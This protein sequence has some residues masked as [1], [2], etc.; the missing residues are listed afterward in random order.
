MVDV[1][2]YCSNGIEAID[3]ID[4][5]CP[6]LLRGFELGNV[7][8]YY[9]RAGRKRR[10]PMP[11]YIKANDYAFRFFH[12]RWRDGLREYAWDATPEQVICTGLYGK[13]HK[14]M[15]D[16]LLKINDIQRNS[17]NREDL[18]DESLFIALGMD[19]IARDFD[20]KREYA[21]NVI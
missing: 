16:F 11:D 17:Q 3:I 14:L 18:I 12:G 4:K 1:K 9:M 21:G 7:I 15:G 19:Q 8:K 2:Y 5:L 20:F 13:P 10:D 6:G